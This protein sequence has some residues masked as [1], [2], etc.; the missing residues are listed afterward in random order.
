MVKTKIAIIGGGISGLYAAYLLEQAGITDY[1]LLEARDRL[2]G[3]IHVK[4]GFDL[5]ATWIWPDLNP[6]LMQL[7]RQ[8][9]IPFFDQSV[10]G[11]FVIE[12]SREKSP[13]RLPNNSWSASSIRLK[14]GMDSLVQA[15]ATRIPTSRIV[16]GQKV[17]NIIHHAHSEIEIISECHD[18]RAEHYQVSS[19]LLAIPS[20]LAIKQVSF[21]PALPQGIVSQWEKMATWM[22][23]HAKYI[24]VYPKAFWKKQGLSGQAR[25]YIGPMAEIHDASSQDEKAALFG[26]LGVPANVRQKV[27]KQDLL[28]HC[29]AQLVRLFGAEAAEPENEFLKDWSTD[30]FTAT[31]MDWK[32]LSSMHGYAPEMTPVDLP[33]NNQII[34][35]ASEWSKDYSGY[36]AGAID[37]A[38]VGVKHLLNS[39]EEA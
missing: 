39:M 14:G 1:I 22:A 2:G 16:M 13:I 11:D 9:E 18:G 15:L 24:A 23:P 21:K 19:V 36:L 34:G 38:M 6:R 30:E 33:W 4:N 25:S 12:E 29:R 32:N 20:R 27:S 26:F 8:F 5:G 37:A 10:K 28:A 3:R 35:I 7:I 31:D 17:I